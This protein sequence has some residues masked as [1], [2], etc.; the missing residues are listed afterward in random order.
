MGTAVAGIEAIAVALDCAVTAVHHSG[1]DQTRG[2]R[3][4]TSLRAAAE[5]SIEVV[6]EG[7]GAE[8]VITATVGKVRD[9]EDGGTFAY[10]LA[11][12]ELG[13]DKWGR[14]VTSCTVELL[15]GEEAAALRTKAKPGNLTARQRDGL[16]ALRDA[17]ERYGRRITDSEDYPSNRKV[18]SETAWRDEFYRRVFSEDSTTHE[19]VRLPTGDLGPD[20]IGPRRRLRREFLDYGTRR[21]SRCIRCKRCICTGC[22]SG[23]TVQAG[24]P[25]YKGAPN[26]PP[27]AA[28]DLS[29]LRGAEMSGSTKAN[30][31]NRGSWP[32]AAMAALDRARARRRTVVAEM[33]DASMQRIEKRPTPAVVK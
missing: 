16:E 14:A 13:I 19:E 29:D 25:P 32:P 1:K 24:A 20:G 10:R 33:L 2:E 31:G 5:A 27:H 12:V 15:G 4:S 6:S 26:A 11:Q 7:K 18:V 22:I 21:C 17:A 28:A 23:E 30:L 8:K 9:G 3:G